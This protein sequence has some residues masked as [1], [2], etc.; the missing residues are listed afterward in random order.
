VYVAGEDALYFTSREGAIKR[1]AL[2][3]G[4]VS[5]VRA[6][7]NRAN[8][9]TLG[10]DGR[11]V[12]CEQGT[13]I[14]RARISRVDPATGAAQTVVDQWCGLRLNSP[15]DVVV[16]SDGS[17]WFTDPAYGFLQGFKPEPEIGDY[18][19]RHDPETGA[20]SVVADSLDKPNGIAFSPDEQVLY[21]TDSGANQEEGSYYVDRPHHVKA[22]DVRDGRRLVNERLF[23]V[24]SPGFPDGI[25]CDSE[26]RVYLSSFDGVL[27]Y[28]PAG[29]EIAEIELPGAVNF[30]F[31]G[32]RQNVLFITTGDAVWAAVLNATG[33]K[34]RAGRVHLRG[35]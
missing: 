27:I 11:L 5:V 13:L 30:T 17:I 26:G 20:T 31:G 9:M 29:E 35:A 18:V 4:H 24:V 12:V 15:N 25:K 3:S 7:A 1:L 21:L 8:G 33:P 23:C 19:L 10:L 32:P 22:F 16:R 6:E 28:S 34:P 2:D 14:E